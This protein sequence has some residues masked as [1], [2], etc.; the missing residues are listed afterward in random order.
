MPYNS[1][2]FEILDVDT[3]APKV[4]N[5]YI[6]SLDRTYLYLRISSNESVVI[7]SMM[8]LLG[9]EVPTVKELKTTTLR[10]ST[11]RITN[12][13]EIYASNSSF[14]APFTKDYIY[15][16]TYLNYDTLTEQTD[17]LLYFYAEDLS[18]NASPV[19]NFTFST[20]AKHIPVHFTLRVNETIA[21]DKIFSAF[22]L[23]TTFTS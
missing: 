9:T 12:V 22:G 17:Y 10:K 13:L 8:T 6:E 1:L 5:Y 15:Y 4:I 23:I 20:L 16:D 3:I 14:V 11:G 21:D 7:Y 19:Y 18:G 2:S